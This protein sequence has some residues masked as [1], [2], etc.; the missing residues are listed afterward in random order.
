MSALIC[1]AQQDVT[2]N[3]VIAKQAFYLKNRWLYEIQVDTSYSSDNSIA[4]SLS[5]KNFVA[6]RINHVS[7]VFI[8]KGPFM[9]VK[10]KAGSHTMDTLDVSFPGTIT[11]SGVTG[12][13][14]INK[15]SGTVNIASGQSSITVT[16]AYVDG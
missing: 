10:V 8:I 15:V 14:T 16:N 4:T 3:R 1:S 6:G 9:S 2:G 5:I 11:A 13:Q 7:K 12:N